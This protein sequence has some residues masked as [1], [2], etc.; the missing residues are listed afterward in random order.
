MSWEVAKLRRISK[1][2]NSEHF[3]DVR[4]SKHVSK[5]KTILKS[6]QRI[7]TSLLS[8]SV[9][10]VTKRR[11]STSAKQK[12]IFFERASETQNSGQG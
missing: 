4:K 9:V 1:P 6:Q 7:N 12:L 5:E 11:I 2:E 3:S 8:L 10:P